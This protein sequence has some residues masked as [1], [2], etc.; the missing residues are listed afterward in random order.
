VLSP[1]HV[2]TQADD[3]DK[4]M[5]KNNKKQQYLIPMEVTPETI[6]DFGIKKEDP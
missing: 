2:Q 4:H 6:R 5:S 3:G 1:R